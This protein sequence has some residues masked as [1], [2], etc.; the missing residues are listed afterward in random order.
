MQTDGLLFFEPLVGTAVTVTA[1]STNVLDLVANRDMGGG[2]YAAPF[3]VAS[4][5][6]AFTS[7]TASA[8]LTISIQGAPDNGAGSPGG[9]QILQSTPAIPLGQLLLGQRP[10]KVP[11]ASVSEMPLAVI[12]TTAI[13]T[14]AGNTITVG[15]A[16]G[17]VQG[18]NIFG[19]PNIPP[20]LTIV[21][22]SGT[23]VTMSSGTGVLSSSG[24]AVPTSFGAPQPR[25]RFLKLNYN[26][27]AT[28]TAGKL[29]AG[30]VLDADQPALY[31]PGFTWPAN[32]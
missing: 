27:S 5:L 24:A 3:V 10:L 32:A 19:N 1:D 29:W 2:G 8:A 28:F 31:P 18:G 6:A 16:T 11:L 25:P 13:T 9:Y 14:A 4:C 7:A 30:I 21:S 17:L 22:I 15:S 20:G 26:C 23:T 12:N